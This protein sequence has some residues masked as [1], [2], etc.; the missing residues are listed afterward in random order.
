VV[1]P[2][3]PQ[4]KRLFFGT[5]VTKRQKTTLVLIAGGVLLA[6]GMVAVFL[7][8]GS[9]DA[10]QPAQPASQR[11]PIRAVR[12]TP[13]RS[14][15]QQRTYTGTIAALRTSDLSFERSARLIA[16]EVEE[17]DRVTPNQVLA[18]LDSRHLLAQKK[19]LE[20]QRAEAAAQLAELIA[21][22]REQTIAAARAQV[23]DL[24]AQ[25][26]L[27]ELNLQR[28]KELAVGDAISPEE[29]DRT[30]FD[31]Q[32]SEARLEAAEQQLDELVA[33]TRKERIEAQRAVV[34]RL[35]AM[36]AGVKLDLEDST[37]RAPFAGRIAARFIDEGTVVMPQ[38]PVLRLVEDD[39]LEA[40]I[41]LPADVAASLEPGTEH[42][43]TVGEATLSA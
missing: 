10:D 27:R 14:Y 6:G 11:V 19:Q 32:A 39:A 40:R 15:L 13:V 2:E 33:G 35:E 38:T 4:A 3:Q 28:R 22:P 30:R 42:D 26:K 24:A 7:L 21:G 16:V 31:L 20:A 36:L 43:V 41:G 34:A 17:G 23:R 1:K 12:I 18:Q 9:S 29:F 37:L 25:T 5:L 8:P